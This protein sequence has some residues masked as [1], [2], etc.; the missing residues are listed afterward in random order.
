MSKYTDYEYEKQIIAQTS[1]SA[2]EYEQK[3]KEL[4]ERLRI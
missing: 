4:A 3:V 1:T 2:E